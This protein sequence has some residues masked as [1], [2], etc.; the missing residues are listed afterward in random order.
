MKTL[1][2]ALSARNES[3]RS[4][5]TAPTKIAVG[6]TMK[7]PADNEERQRRPE[8]KFEYETVDDKRLDVAH[9][10]TTSE[11]D[12]KKTIT[13]TTLTSKIEGDNDSQYET[14]PPELL[15]NFSRE[16]CDRFLNYYRHYK[17]V[18]LLSTSSK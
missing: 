10:E 13:D 7:S 12:A 8:L 3:L 14:L 17:S 5:P 6:S 11:N 2:N 16:D 15:C 9:K 1:I 18:K 4:A